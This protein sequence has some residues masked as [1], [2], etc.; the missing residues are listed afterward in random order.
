MK[1]HFEFSGIA[2]KQFSK[3]DKNIQQAIFEKMVFFEKMKNPLEQAMKMVGYNEIYRF[4][5]GDYRV[6]V[7]PEPNGELVILLV[8][9]IA[10]RKEVYKRF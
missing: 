7:R 6:I 5:I 9:K 4:R 10:H 3:L 2:K 8:L 1:Y